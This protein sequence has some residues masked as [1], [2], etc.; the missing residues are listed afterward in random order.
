MIVSV[1]TRTRYIKITALRAS[2]DQIQRFWPFF[3]TGNRKELD[4]F[5]KK[6][7]GRNMTFWLK[8]LLLKTLILTAL[9]M[10]PFRIWRMLPGWLAHLCLRSPCQ[11]GRGTTQQNN[12]FDLVT[13]FSGGICVCVCLSV[14]VCVCVFLC[15]CLCGFMSLYLS[16]FLFISVCLMSSVFLL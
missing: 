6:A 2:W 9:T 12:Y 4:I 1:N 5:S 11:S 10:N 14:C 7:G 16:F 13:Y 3:V 15:V 8:Y